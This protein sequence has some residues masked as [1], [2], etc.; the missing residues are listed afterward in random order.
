MSE[1]ADLC[2]VEV[3]LQLHVES[4]YPPAVRQLDRKITAALLCRPLADPAFL[5]TEQADERGQPVIPIMV[6]GQRIDGLA[7]RWILA[8]G[9]RAIEGTFH[10][11]PV[12][13][14]RGNWIYLVAAKNRE[15]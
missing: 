14:S 2:R 7:V 9:A 15:V 4:P 5:L 10:P 3:G 13:L 6:A 11:M 8:F 1:V 12:L